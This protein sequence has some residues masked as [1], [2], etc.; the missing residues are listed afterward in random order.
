MKLWNWSD[1]L[2]RLFALVRAHIYATLFINLVFVYPAVARTTHLGL[3]RPE[4]IGS[5]DIAGSGLMFAA[6]WYCSLRWLGG[7]AGFTTNFRDRD[8]SLQ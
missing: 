1:A 4:A 5:S 8:S 6:I 3:A 2:N 7:A